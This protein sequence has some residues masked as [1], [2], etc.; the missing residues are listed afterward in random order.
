MAHTED[1]A[2]KIAELLEHE[3]AGWS[4]DDIEHHHRGVMLCAHLVDQEGLQA[5]RDTCAVIIQTTT[6]AGGWDD[7]LGALDPDAE[8]EYGIE[9]PEMDAICDDNGDQIGSLAMPADCAIDGYGDPCDDPDAAIAVARWGC[10]LNPD[11]S[12][13]FRALVADVAEDVAEGWIVT[14][15][16]GH[17]VRITLDDGAQIIVT[18]LANTVLPASPHGPS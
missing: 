6:F 18:R 7:A 16:P 10:W 9:W 8:S 3:P 14:L 5:A 11:G 2:R 15:D 13:V 4:R 17:A 1:N 12:E